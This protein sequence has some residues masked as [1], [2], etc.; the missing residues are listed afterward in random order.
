MSAGY[1]APAIAQ[2]MGKYKLNLV[3]QDVLQF[4][5]FFLPP[6]WMKSQESLLE[7]T[8]MVIF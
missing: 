7:P 2:I 6:L 8:L 5:S 3:A 1:L 4:F